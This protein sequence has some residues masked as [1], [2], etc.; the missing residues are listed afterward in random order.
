MN[1]GSPGAIIDACTLETFAVTG[2]L[3]LLKS[4]YGVRARW[5]ETI[6]YE[7]R[8]GL[9]EEPRNQA[10]LDATW[11]GEPLDVDFDPESLRRIEQ[12]RRGLGGTKRESMKHLGEAEVIYYLETNAPDWLFVSDDRT[13]VDFARNRHLNAIDTRQVLTDCYI[14]GEI[15]CPA[16]FDLLREMRA[17]GRGVRVPRNHQLVCPS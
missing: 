13:A 3:D 8:R 6:R 4:H 14:S 11:L 17:A 16:A 7:V 1:Y 15:G 2:R 12:I 5:T 10:V 9:L